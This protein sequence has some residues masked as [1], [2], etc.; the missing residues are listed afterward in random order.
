MNRQLVAHEAQECCCCVRPAAAAARRLLS[1]G[2]FWPSDPVPSCRLKTKVVV[3]VQIIVEIGFL[4]EET[5]CSAKTRA[6]AV[7]ERMVASVVVGTR[8]FEGRFRSRVGRAKRKKEDWSS[9]LERRHTARG[10][11]KSR[12]SGRWPSLS[13]QV[14][15]LMRLMAPHQQRPMPKASW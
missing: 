1:L 10:G 12:R 14:V 15:R 9:M 2:P 7:P 6:T 11:C 3:E 5:S 8:L 4:G 13:E